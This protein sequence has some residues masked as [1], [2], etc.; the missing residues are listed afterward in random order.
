MPD[1]NISAIP[2]FQDNYIWLLHTGG[3][4]CAVVDPGD[5]EPVRRVLQQ[6]G[7]RLTTI[8]I[9][10]H[11]ADHIGGVP[12]LA[13]EWNPKLIGPADARIRGL[14]TVVG[15]GDIAQVPE[16]GLEFKVLEVPGH[17][18]S[19]IAF[20]GHGR[21]FCGDTLFSVGCGRLFEG[22]A[23]QMQQSLDKMAVL[24]GDTLVYCAHEYT[25][26]NCRF[27]LEVEPENPA[28]LA[29]VQ[30]V[31]AARAA[32]KITLPSRLDEELAVNPFLRSRESAVIRA[33]QERNPTA[34]AGTSTLQ[35]IRQWKDSY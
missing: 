15:Q 22:T 31:Q 7:L 8:L 32:G 18:R 25:Q 10:H 4:E 24:P 21:L 19:H 6:T 30:Q 11:H 34:K 9:T 27:A 14:H 35:V 33:A 2:A 23:A 17:T 5:A 3:K 1:I 12:S 26:A 29:K 28:L 20:F 13:E 16:L